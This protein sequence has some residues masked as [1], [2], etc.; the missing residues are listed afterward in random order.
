MWQ[1]SHSQ[2]SSSSSESGASRNARSASF[3]AGAPAV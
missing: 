2:R 1:A 3:S